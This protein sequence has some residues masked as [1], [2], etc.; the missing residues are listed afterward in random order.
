M[1][2]NSY[3][4]DE[5]R[6]ALIGLSRDLRGLAYALNSKVPYMMLF[7]WIYPDYTPILIRAVELWAHDPAVTTPVLK[8][9][10]ELVQNRS[11]RLIFDVSCP[12]GILLFRETS[13]LICCYGNR[14]LNIDVPKG[15]IYQMRLKGIAVC[16]HMLKAILCGNYVNFGVFKLYGDDALDNVLK[17]A[18]KLIL[19]IPHSDLL[20]SFLIYCPIFQFIKDIF[21]FYDFLG[22]SKTVASILHPIRMSSTRSYYLP[23]DN[24]AKCIFVY[25]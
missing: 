25:S 12:N 24:G 4:S 20:V 21:F 10:A 14:I 9:F 7:D 17:I 23:I 3:P 1:D 16:F 22:I 11:Q 6:K 5:V 18:A 13:K 8:F 19:S 2:T 15:Q